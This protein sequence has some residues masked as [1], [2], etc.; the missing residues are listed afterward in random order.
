MV[1]KEGVVKYTLAY[2]PG[3]PVAYQL[4]A[5]LNAWRRIL[6][7]TNLVGQ[8]A[9]RYG[10]AGY[11]NVSQRLEVAIKGTQPRFAISGTQTGGLAELTEDHFTIVTETW[12]AEN[13]VVATGPIMPSSESLTHGMLYRVD[14][15][16]NTIMHAH[17]S[18]IWQNASRL[19]IPSTS[20]S[21]AYGTPEMAEEVRR[22]FRDSPVR[23]RKILCMGGHTDGVMSFSRTAEEAGCVMMTYLA[24]ALA[25]R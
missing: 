21:V 22:L 8:D 6:F 18:E 10:G 1:T 16:V 19:G 9:N 25:L 5:V 12:P 7:L 24:R 23:E 13:R 4:I 17:S 14:H 15:S 2:M 3:S 11:G 20:A